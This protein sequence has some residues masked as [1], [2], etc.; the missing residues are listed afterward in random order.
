MTLDVYQNQEL[1]NLN[2][3]QT[4]E[5]REIVKKTFKFLGLSISEDPKIRLLIILGIIVVLL[6]IASIITSMSRR[7]PTAPARVSPTPSPNVTP[8]PSEIS[9][10]T[11]LPEDLKTKFKA[12]DDNINTNIDFSPP[13]IDTEV[14]L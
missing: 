5:D 12:I 4:K 3:L 10:L 7:T 13:Q 14:G 9:N 2:P 8:L 6:L 11:R 1:D